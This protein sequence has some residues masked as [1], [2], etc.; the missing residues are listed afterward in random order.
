MKRP[1]LLRVVRAMFAAILIWGV[2]SPL[3]GSAPA[4]QHSTLDDRL[5][6]QQDRKESLHLSG[7]FHLEKGTQ[8][9]YLILRAQI[10]RGNYIASVTQPKSPTKIKV[11]PGA[12]FKT[13][14]KFA[15]DRT[16]EVI[17]RDP[18]MKT[19]IEKH[20]GM[21]QFFIPIEVLAGFD[22]AKLE[23]VI[24]FDGQV[25]SDE[26]FCM[27]VRGKKVSAMF[28]GYFKPQT[29]QQESKKSGLRR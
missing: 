27:P 25:C 4:Q 15:S 28:A 21:V 26:G 29:A 24:T 11:T 18:I 17:K 23:P 3:S 22:P 10:P 13:T 12:G 5:Q 7:R 20:R 16:A 9:G 19:R 1:A 8:Q 6:R 14:G 2:L